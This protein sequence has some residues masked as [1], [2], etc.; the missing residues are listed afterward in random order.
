M[1]RCRR[2]ITEIE[3]QLRTGHTDLEGLL[4]ALADW[5]AELRLIEEE[6]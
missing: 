4:L 6:S 5:G 1:E 2:E 3:T